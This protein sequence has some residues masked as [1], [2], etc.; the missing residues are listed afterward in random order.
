M[1][2]YLF[3]GNTALLVNHIF[4]TLLVSYLILLLIEQ[5]W[6]GFVSLYLNLN[7]LL[8]AVIIA[9]ILDVFSEHNI[10][11]RKKPKI[12]DYIF[13]IILGV[14]GFFIISF[15]TQQLGFLSWIISVIAGI[16]IILLS[17]LILEDEEKTD[18][19]KIKE[20]RRRT[21]VFYLIITL[22]FILILNLISILLA[23]FTELSYLE[24]LRIVFGSIYVLFLPGFIMSYIFFPK[25]K[26][27]DSDETE[28]HEENEI[29]WIERI[30][31]SFALS[32]S[33]VPLSVF[34]LNLIGVKIS[35]IN[36]FLIILGIIIISLEI[37]FF[38]IKQ[39]RKNNSKSN[40]INLIFFS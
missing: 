39:L 2:K 7:Y 3:R 13:I 37:L 11:E 19:K 27:F 34:Y 25:T 36:V 17:I 15:K 21:K 5:I 9:G 32:I 10:I 31:L 16:L 38:R 24:S 12:T 40:K 35:A 22:G 8:V 23:I 4:Q 30:A 18:H 28:K 6:K 26:P 29:D 20:K 14:A 1:E 33:I